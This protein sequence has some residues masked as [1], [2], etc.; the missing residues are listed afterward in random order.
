MARPNPHQ[1]RTGGT[2]SV[3]VRCRGSASVEYTL[4]VAAIAAVVGLA[5]KDD[6]TPMVEQSFK[7]F[8]NA[9][10]AAQ[11]PSRTTDGSSGPAG[12]P[13][14][15]GTARPSPTDSPTSSPSPSGTPTES[16]SGSGSPSST[17]TST[18][19]G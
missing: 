3:G 10:S 7:G 5:L 8:M 19:A 15:R 14:D 18:V 12:V 4:L 6:L 9:F 16:P 13:T 17:I 11:D 2:R 1:R